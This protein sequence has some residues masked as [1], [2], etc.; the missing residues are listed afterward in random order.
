L[1]P[2][3]AL[4]DI[5]DLAE[6]ISLNIQNILFALE[7]NAIHQRSKPE[8]SSKVPNPRRFGPPTGIPHR[9]RRQE[10]EASHL[11]TGVNKSK[12]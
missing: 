8:D 9:H 11:H 12:A 2:K 6:A 3:H 5:S 1:K 10:E 4:R 7:E